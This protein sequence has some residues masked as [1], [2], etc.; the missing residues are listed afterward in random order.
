MQKIFI[1]DFQHL[2]INKVDVDILQSRAQFYLKY[3]LNG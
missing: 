2:I 1:N 3:L